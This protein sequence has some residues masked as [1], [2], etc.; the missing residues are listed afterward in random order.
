MSINYISRIESYFTQFE[1]A[2]DSPIMADPLF[3]VRINPALNSYCLTGEDSYIVQP[4][5]M[6]F[7]AQPFRYWR[8]DI[9]IR[10][11][12]MCSSFHRG[13]L[14]VF[15]EPNIAQWAIMIP[16][17]SLNKN[18]FH[19]ID[20]Q[21]T[22]SVEFCI[23]WNHPRAWA[24]TQSAYGADHNW[25]NFSASDGSYEYVNGFMS[26]V[27]YTTLTAPLSSP[28]IV[29]VYASCP[30]LMVNVL[31]NDAMPTSR[32]IA[33]SYTE[34][35]Y[36]G[37]VECVVLNESLATTD[38]ICQH[39]FGEQIV[40]FRSLLKRYATTTVIDENKAGSTDELLSATIL[41]IPRAAPLYNSSVTIPTLAGYLPLAYMGVRGGVRKRIRLV[42][43]EA[44][45]S[46]YGR[47]NVKLGAV[48]P[49]SAEALSWQSA[50]SFMLDRGT[51]AFVPHTN[52]GVEYEIPYYS[53]NL[54]EFAFAED[55][56]GSNPAGDM[57]GFW[58]KTHI[59]EFE[60][61]DVTSATNRVVVDHAIGED[62]M[63]FRYSGAPY[64]ISAL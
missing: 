6:S 7:A 30:N 53:P 22:Q 49:N 60:H 1:W 61:T 46:I 54:F 32:I 27:P 23:K 50:P 31:D 26:V 58:I 52:G 55:G 12:I 15:F 42:S 34:T 59:I 43:S 41:N 16:D 37:D 51:V 35:A 63:F 17:I 64:Y 28:V 11:E 47:V 62:F 25:L 14:A 39:H 56:I 33:E 10:L 40:S 19:I 38:N 3:N 45:P 20:I 9:H 18:Y 29:N 48:G 21:Q 5:A 36:D 8:G 2:D 13:K 44:S 4:T 57:I 24:R